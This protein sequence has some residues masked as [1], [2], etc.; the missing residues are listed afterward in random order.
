MARLLIALDPGVG[1]GPTELAAAWNVDAEAQVAGS[2]RAEETSGS[3]FFPGVVE[4]V[5][6]P[7]L[8]NV[9]SSVVYDLLKQLMAKVRPRHHSEEQG[10]EFAE[11][12]TGDGNRLIVVRM[13]NTPS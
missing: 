6:V 11:V 2:A 9:G 4:L 5:V 10:L 12:T 8:V 7:L 1:V 13:G 3:A